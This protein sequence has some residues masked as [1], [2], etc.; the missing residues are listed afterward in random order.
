MVDEK[1]IE[2]L[3]DKRH[4]FGLS[5]EEADELGK[6]F[7]DREGKPYSN[8]K[9]SKLPPGERGAEVPGEGRSASPGQEMPAS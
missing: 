8:A 1:R 6:L 2:E 4:E 5:D 9:L 3:I 7:A